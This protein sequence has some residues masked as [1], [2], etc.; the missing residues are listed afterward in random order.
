MVGRQAHVLEVN[1]RIQGS[2]EVVERASGVGVFD[3]HM[4]ACRGQELPSAGGVPG[5]WGRRIVYAPA[6]LLTGQLGGL[7]FVKDVP[8]P[9]VPMRAGAPVCTVLARSSSSRRCADLLKEREK[10]V[11]SL[12]H[13][14]A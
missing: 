14:P 3:A 9:N 7:G 5:F 11:I 1:P 8:S 2:L 10:R 6:D 12:L 13:Q 4:R